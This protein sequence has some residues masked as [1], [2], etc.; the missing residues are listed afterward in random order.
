[1]LLSQEHFGYLPPAGQGGSVSAMVCHAPLA[2]LAPGRRRSSRTCTSTLPPVCTSGS[3][4]SPAGS[5]LSHC[6]S[7]V[8]AA[9]SW[10]ALCRAT[11]ASSEQSD[12]FRSPRRRST[13]AA[14]GMPGP[15]RS[16]CTKVG[17]VGRAATGKSAGSRHSGRTSSRLARSAGTRNKAP[18]CYLFATI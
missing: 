5:S 3:T 18:V 10:A 4:A 16:R 8:R 15:A 14:P 1:V 17:M 9:A 12:Q 7:A 2:P 11:A 6:S 13:A